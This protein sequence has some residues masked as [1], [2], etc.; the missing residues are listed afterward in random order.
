MPDQD[1]KLLEHFR[2]PKNVGII[3]NSDGYGRVENPVNGYIT[4]MYIKIENDR[5]ADI[6]FK[7]F[8][9]VVTIASASALSE[10]VKNKKLQDIINTNNTIENLIE[11]IKNDLG[12]IPD[13]NWHCPP[14]AIQALLITILD[15]FRKKKDEKNINK[16]EKKLSELKQYYSMMLEKQQ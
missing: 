4:D 2:N 11:N 6:K 8:G 3:E 5:I 12:E 10:S 15:Y 16:I 7:T 1:Q 9:C 14:T 13:K